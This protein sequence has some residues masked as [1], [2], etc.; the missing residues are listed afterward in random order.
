MLAK[1]SGDEENAA[2]GRLLEED[3]VEESTDP[4]VEDGGE[5]AKQRRPKQR[6]RQK[7]GIKLRLGVSRHA[8]DSGDPD[9][10]GEDDTDHWHGSSVDG[11]RRTLSGRMPVV[12][13]MQGLVRS[14]TS[15]TLESVKSDFHV[16]YEPLFRV[17]GWH[18]KRL[19]CQWIG[20][21][22]LL[23]IEYG[24][25]LAMGFGVMASCEAEQVPASV[26]S[27]RAAPTCHCVPIVWLQLSNVATV[28][29]AVYLLFLLLS[30]PY[31]DTIFLTYELITSAGQLAMMIIIILGYFE[32]VV[33]PQGVFIGVIVFILMGQI[34]SQVRSRLHMTDRSLSES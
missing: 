4:S 2:T 3:S 19:A 23:G 30:R 1:A 26:S 25:G 22:L 11:M 16:L 8:G 28:R 5:L 9:D 6:A 31:D 10:A 15:N 27:F 21:P 17:E 7:G 34:G 14:A 13:S 12:E 24:V 29:V 18:S 33:A 32:L 20:P